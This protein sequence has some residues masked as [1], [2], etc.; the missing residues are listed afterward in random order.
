VTRCTARRIAGDEC[1][2]ARRWVAECVK[3]TADDDDKRIRL[4]KRIFSASVPLIA[5]ANNRANA[6]NDGIVERNLTAT[7]NDACR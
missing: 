4:W 7:K 5:R 3:W 2:I 6:D 1:V